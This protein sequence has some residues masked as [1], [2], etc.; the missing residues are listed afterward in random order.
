MDELL[1]LPA[2][3][4][5]IGGQGLQGTYVPYPYLMHIHLV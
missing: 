1:L 5:E 4:A 3:A 2:K